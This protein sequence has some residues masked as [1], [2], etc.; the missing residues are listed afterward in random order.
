MKEVR[1]ITIE[2]GVEV[3]SKSMEVTDA[4]VGE[5]GTVV[6]VDVTPEMIV[7]FVGGRPKNKPSPSA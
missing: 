7:E 5:F 2:N 4:M 6:R 3:D 1:I